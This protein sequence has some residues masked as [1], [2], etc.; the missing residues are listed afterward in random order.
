MSYDYTLED[1]KAFA[2]YNG[3]DPNAVFAAGI[4]RAALIQIAHVEAAADL[5]SS[6]LVTSRAFHNVVV[7]ERDHAVARVERMEA[8]AKG[9]ANLPY[10]LVSY[11]Y[12]M[13]GYSQGILE[14]LQRREDV[15]PG[16]KETIAQVLTR[17]DSENTKHGIGL[18]SSTPA[19]ERSSN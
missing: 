17:I 14:G 8:A 9:T 12:A 18:P 7:R 13:L 15:G 6:E 5:L 2:N 11:L 16:A 19:A 4:A 10:P 1:L 3:A